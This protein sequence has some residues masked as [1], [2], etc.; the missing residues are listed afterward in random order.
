MAPLSTSAHQRLLDLEA[1]ER[2][3]VLGAVVLAGATLSLGS[4]AF[5]SPGAPR[6]MTSHGSGA[7]R[8][9]APP[10]G[11]S[12]PMLGAL[13]AALPLAALGALAGA[14]RSKGRAAPATQAAALLT[15]DGEGRYRFA[16]G[17]SP[18]SAAP[19]EP[20]YGGWT[21]GEVGATLP[22]CEPK[23]GMT[24]WDP[25]GFCAGDDIKNFDKYRAA[26]I[27]HGRVAMIATVGLVAQHSFKF[28][29]LVAPDGV[30]SLGNVP[31]GFSAI[32]EAPGSYGFGTLVLLAGIIE[33]GVLSDKGRAPG[34]MGDPFEW[35][36]ALSYAEFDEKLM[37]TY[38][39]EHGR[40][41]M[42]GFIGSIAAEYL[43]GLDAVAQWDAASNGAT[44]L[45]HTTLYWAA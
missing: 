27:K 45:F 26:E 23:E 29:F 7:L 12:Q 13:A 36:K 34:D 37:K 8:G 44:Q 35:K 42:F 31:S 20:Y 33:L 21:V 3:S 22:L 38:E 10:A 18:A 15:K 43:T 5:V 14:T 19:S 41:A 25:A 28:P 4:L 1:M 17:A 16:T 6:G 39:L 9:S 11:A 2:K 40:L 30:Y 24:M 32:T